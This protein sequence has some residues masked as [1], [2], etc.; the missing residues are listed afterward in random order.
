MMTGEDK[1]AL[2]FNYIIPAGML[3]AP[4]F[5]IYGLVLF[6]LMCLHIFFDLSY[7]GFVR[8]SRFGLS[9]RHPY[10]DKVLTVLIV[11]MP[12]TAFLLHNGAV[13]FIPVMLALHILSEARSPDK[14][15]PQRSKFD[16]PLW[17]Y[18]VWLVLYFIGLG[19]AIIGQAH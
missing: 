12:F 18:S 3:L 17:K 6:G 14:P 4:V 15:A 1:K 10:I 5:G 2:F 13:I 16:N 19:A 7:Q 11:V 8:Q 9:Q